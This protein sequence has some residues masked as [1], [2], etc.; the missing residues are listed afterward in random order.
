MKAHLLKHVS[1]ELR[2]LLMDDEH[3]PRLLADGEAMRVPMSMMDSVKPPKLADGKQVPSHRAGWRVKGSLATDSKM[4]ARRE[5]Y[6]EYDERLSRAYLGDAAIESQTTGFGSAPSTELR[7]SREGD[8]CTIDGWPGHLR[9]VNGRLNC[10]PDNKGSQDAKTVK[11]IRDEAYQSYE[12]DLTNAWRGPINEH[13][14]KKR[15][16][17]YRDPEGRETGTAEEQVEDGKRVKDSKLEILYAE[18]DRELENAWKTA[19]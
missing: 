8:A 14:G 11:Q 1:P 17:Q 13:D 6:R 10:V 19:K 2:A 5:L 12:N 18:R 15:K 7:G 16:T 4:D 9:N 3:D